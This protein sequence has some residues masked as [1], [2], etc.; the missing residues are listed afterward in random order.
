MRNPHRYWDG[1]RITYPGIAALPVALLCLV[2]IGLVGLVIQRH[3][4]LRCVVLSQRFH[5][6]R[7]R[8]DWG[9]PAGP[10]G[11]DPAAFG[12]NTHPTTHASCR[13]RDAA[14]NIINK[15]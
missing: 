5:R 8:C 4:A 13:T 10:S 12:S 11:G 2:G 3:A 9:A 15:E 1:D 7:A 6:T 14:N